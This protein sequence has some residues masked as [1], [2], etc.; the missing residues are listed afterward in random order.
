[1]QQGRRDSLKLSSGEF[2][3]GMSMSRL[4]CFPRKTTR[5]KFKFPADEHAQPS[6][7]TSHPNHQNHPNIITSPLSSSLSNFNGPHDLLHLI[8][9][10]FVS[11]FGCVVRIGSN[12]PCRA[13]AIEER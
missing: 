7:I 3:S 6:Q 12:A 1:M 13:L 9:L 11:G 8:I 5:K 2:W 4:K 10:L